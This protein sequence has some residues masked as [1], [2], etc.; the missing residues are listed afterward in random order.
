MKKKILVIGSTGMLGQAFMELLKTANLTMPV[1][2]ARK[3]ADYELDITDSNALM[4]LVHKLDPYLVINCSALI[5]IDVC[6]ANKELAWLTNARPVLFLAEWSRKECKS[7]IQISTDHFY[8]L[9]SNKAHKEEDKVD[10][11][12]EYARS[13]YAAELFALDSPRALVI[14][15]SLIGL[16]GWEKN[17][18]FEWALDVVEKDLSAS[19]FEDAFTSSIDVETFARICLEL[20]NKNVF[21]LYNLAA[22]EVY[23]KKDL[24]IEIAKQLGKTLTKVKTGSIKELQIERGDSL[25]LDVSQ[26]ESVLGRRLPNLRE[27]VSELLKQKNMNVERD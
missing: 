19:L 21:G 26:V 22:S 12:N 16:R 6:E 24:V 4:S 8:R 10:L 20:I 23:S 11:I 15:T 27:V 25:G 13:K 7:L 3:N 1:G 5:D 18:F 17:T 2:V 14:R 9:D